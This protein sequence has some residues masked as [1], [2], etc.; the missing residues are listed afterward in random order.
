MAR[1][2]LALGVPEI[3]LSLDGECVR[4]KD[5]IKQR[6]KLSPQLQNK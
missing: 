3:Y 2:S 1:A 5:K 4:P 6:L